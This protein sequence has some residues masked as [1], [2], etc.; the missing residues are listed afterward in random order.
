MSA[1]NRDDSRHHCRFTK[2]AARLAERMFDIGVT[3]KQTPYRSVRVAALANYRDQ[4]GRIAIYSGGM[5]AIVAPMTNMLVAA[6]SALARFDGGQRFVWNIEVGGH[7]LYVVV[8]VE[9]F[10]QL[11]HARGRAGIEI[12][13]VLGNAGNLADFSL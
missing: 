3:E 11:E 13:G 10:H 1:A 5:G 4:I 9:R 12:D 8:V 2:S 6:R 7:T